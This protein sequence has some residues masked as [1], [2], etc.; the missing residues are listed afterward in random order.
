MLGTQSV[1]ALWLNGVASPRA[2]SPATTASGLQVRSRM[3]CSFPTSDW[4][5][6]KGPS[7]PCSPSAVS[8]CSS[9]EAKTSIPP[10]NEFVQ[11][12]EPRAIHSVVLLARSEGCLAY[13]GKWLYPRLEIG[14][15]SGMNLN[16]R[17]W[18]L[19]GARGNRAAIEVSWEGK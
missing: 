18:R 19:D 15:I 5:V 6:C 1:H 8:S 2:V 16:T 11:P 17:L 10:A 14:I 9:P 4:S 3:Q 13:W 12:I 7:W